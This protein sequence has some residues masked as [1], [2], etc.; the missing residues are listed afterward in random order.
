MVFKLIVE[1]EMDSG[2]LRAE[3]MSRAE[4]NILMGLESQRPQ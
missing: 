3:R 2:Q 4:S 1:K